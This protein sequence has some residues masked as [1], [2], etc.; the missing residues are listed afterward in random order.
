MA[1]CFV[2]A[3]CLLATLA[4]LPSR[5]NTVQ[6]KIAGAVDE[7][8]SVTLPERA[9]LSDGAL[10]ARI[11]T[12]SYV[13]GACWLRSSLQAEQARMKAGIIFDL[14]STHR[15]AVAQGHKLLADVS[16]SLR[17]WVA[18][19]PVTGRQPALLDPRAV[20]V[21]PRHNHLLEDGDTLYYPRRPT[22]VRLVGALKHACQLPQ[23]ALRDARE[24]I[25]DC[26]SSPAADPDWIF[27]IQPDGRIFK[28]GIALW[29]R[30]AAIALAPGGVIY[31]PLRQSDVRAVDPDLN[32][33]LATFLATQPVAWSEPYP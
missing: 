26:A 32:D 11:R 23:V 29:N 3:I 15:H 18:S 16:A 4:A 27:V 31:V 17:D 9:R 25:K 13:L 6:V 21:S 12:D 14:D 10:V 5:A 8:G 2:F 7:P 24:Y 30:T 19:M 20:E 1:Q 22:T 28:Q 33:E